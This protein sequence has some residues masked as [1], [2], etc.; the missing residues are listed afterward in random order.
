MA[1]LGLL[2]VPESWEAVTHLAKRKDLGGLVDICNTILAAIKHALESEERRLKPRSPLK[3]RPWTVS[4][5][6][7]EDW[8]RY[9]LVKELADRRPE[10]EFDREVSRVDLSICGH[11]DVE[12]KGPLRIDENRKLCDDDIK[13]QQS[14]ILKDF[15]KQQSR[16]DKEPNPEHFVLL[17]LHA[18]KLVF[19]SGSVQRWLARLES[20]IKDSG[21]RIDAHQSTP[22]VLNGDQGLMKCCLYRVC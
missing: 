11:A 8:V 5:V 6:Y 22:F 7:T 2:L 10:W 17:I 1:I 3:R 21:I 19:C 4:G 9:L 18:R 20:N 14:A 13:K 15:E 16:A 12:L